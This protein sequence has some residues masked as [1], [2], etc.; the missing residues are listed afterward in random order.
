M[1]TTIIDLEQHL[2][3]GI[4]V[5][6]QMFRLSSGRRGNDLTRGGDP[7]I[8]GGNPRLW[9][10][11]LSL[12]A[13]TQEDARELEALSYRLTDP[14]TL[15]R[16]RDYRY[17]RTDA[18]TSVTLTS[19]AASRS[20]LTLGGLPAGLRLSAG[21]YIGFI[22]SGRQAHHMLT[23]SAVASGAGAA[24]VD[25]VPSVREGFSP[26]SPVGINFPSLLAF[27]PAGGIDGYASDGGTPS[28]LS[29]SWIQYV[30]EA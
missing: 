6:G 27:I 13:R 20:R 15:I 8:S 10:G 25:V 19:V 7:I 14:E 12:A 1:P 9:G 11:T 26:G 22:Y 18:G 4:R 29:I 2:G 21:D 5:A 23:S 3:P 30:E 28:G 24:T 16:V 17:R